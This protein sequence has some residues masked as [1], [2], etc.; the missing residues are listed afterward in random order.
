[1]RR[2]RFQGAPCPG[3]SRMIKDVIIGKMPARG[4]GNGHP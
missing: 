2:G 1:L 4:Q 3:M